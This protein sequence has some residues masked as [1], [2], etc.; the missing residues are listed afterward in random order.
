MY[1]KSDNHHNSNIRYNSIRTETIIKSQRSSILF[2]SST[3]SARKKKLRIKKSDTSSTRNQKYPYLFIY[4]R[5]HM[6]E[7]RAQ[8]IEER[9][10]RETNRGGRRRATKPLGKRRGWR[11]VFKKGSLASAHCSRHRSKY[12]SLYLTELVP[13]IP[14]LPMINRLN[15]I[16][17]R[18][19]QRV[20]D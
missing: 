20:R 17:H 7:N 8:L 10:G 6:R 4:L 1:T 3:F 15:P 2:Y 5:V 19:T 18:E 13:T 12:I 9:R 14:N 16:I 11:K